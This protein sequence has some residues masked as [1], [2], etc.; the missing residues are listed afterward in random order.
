[1]KELSLHILDIVQNSINAAAS[2]ITIIIAEDTSKDTLEIS[3]EDNGQDMNSEIVEKVKDPFYT[4]RSTRKIG[5]GIPLFLAASERCGGRLDIKS[6]PGKGTRVT[7][8]FVH[9]HI[10]RAPLGNMWDTLAGLVTCNQDIDFKYIH[11][12]NNKLFEFDT[13]EIKKLL[14]G[15]PVNSPGVYN[16]IRDY[17]KQGINELYGGIV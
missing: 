9:S 4:S 13:I 7:A 14:D 17:I 2:L 8:Y 12:Y 11:K 16:W 5:L 6:E 1:M 3:V 15:V 10:D